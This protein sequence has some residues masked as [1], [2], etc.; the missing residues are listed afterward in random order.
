MA[1]SYDSLREKIRA[2]KVI[3]KNNFLGFMKISD[4]SICSGDEIHEGMSAPSRWV[5]FGVASS[6][7][8]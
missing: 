3:S 4:K 6:S 2:L 1:R 8:I 5:L 7:P